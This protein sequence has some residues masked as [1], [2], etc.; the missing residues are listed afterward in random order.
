MEDP[1]PARNLLTTITCWLV[2]LR[3]RC[4]KRDCEEETDRDENMFG[5]IYFQLLVNQNL[6][7]GCL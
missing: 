6:E 3:H 4:L 5:E 7:D 1:N 2:K